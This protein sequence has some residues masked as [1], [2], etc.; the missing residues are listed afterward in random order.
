MYLEKKPEHSAHNPN[1]QK[2]TLNIQR[3]RQSHKKG[4]LNIQRLRQSH[5]KGTLKT[6][7]TR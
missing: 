2:E 3:L 6:Q 5:K 1:P 4:T 7:H